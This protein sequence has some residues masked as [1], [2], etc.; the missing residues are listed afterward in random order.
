MRPPQWF[1]ADEAFKCLDPQREFPA[2]KRAFGP[3]VPRP[4]PFQ[5]CR[6]QVLGSVD[7]TEVFR[8]PTL[9]RG[10]RD[11]SAAFRDEVERLDHHALASTGSHLRPPRD[12]IGG[13]PLVSK[14][15]DLKRCGK[16][17]LGIRSAE[18]SYYLHM[19]GMGFIRVD[20]AFACE[21]M[22]RSQLEIAEGAYRPAIL[23]VGA[24]VMIDRIK[25]RSCVGRQSFQAGD[26]AHCLRDYVALCFEGMGTSI[27]HRR[28]L[29]LE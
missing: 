11:S 14:I 29:L 19:P 20:R 25:P 21:N 28:I 18:L 16:E 26:A 22:E 9:D 2:G 7:D 24:C 13:A 27:A 23:P 5:V 4:E 1:F 15:D 3:N 10:L 17:D 12:C 8:P 6:Q